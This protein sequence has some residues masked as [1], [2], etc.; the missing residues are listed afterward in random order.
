MTDV[1]TH[2]DLELVTVHCRIDPAEFRV[3]DNYAFLLHNKRTEQ[4]TLIDAPEAAP[5]IAALDARGW[6]LHHIVI[7]H[8][9]NDHIE[10]LAE[11]V[12]RYGAKVI[13][14]KADAHRLPPLDIAV[15]EGDTLDLSGTQAQI[16]DVS[17]HT[18]GHIAIY[19]PAAHAVFTADSLMA[20]G[21]GRL[22][23]GTARQM[24]QSMQKLR[25]L[26][27]NTLV[28]SGHEYT[29]ANLRFAMTIEP[30][31]PQLQTRAADIAAQRAKSLPTVPS[32]LGVEKQTNPYL[33]ADLQPL[34]AA[35][36]MKDA[37]AEDVFGHVRQLKDTF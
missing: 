10:G 2:A 20:L 19:V 24:W 5:L 26:P 31:N 37:T 4:T 27:D 11:L 36:D 9:H 34:K 29:E 3:N 12:D 18:L 13:G 28:C 21:C 17:G 6:G 1:A 32:R 25:A 35:L 14:A 23:E 16:I 8:H 15:T 33:R 22:F 30:D 7:T